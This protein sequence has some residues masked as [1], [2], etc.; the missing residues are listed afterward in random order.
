MADPVLRPL[1][2]SKEFHVY[3]EQ[4]GMFDVFME[5]FRELVMWKPKDPLVYI[6]D[7]LPRISRSIYSP[8]V[9]ILGEYPGKLVYSLGFPEIIINEPV[10]L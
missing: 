10:Y 1:Q 4:N 7:E 2:W 8:R 9:F 6:R 3:A 5:L